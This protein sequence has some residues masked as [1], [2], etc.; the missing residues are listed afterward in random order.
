MPNV[1]VD[2]IAK[3]FR[4]E[5]VTRIKCAN[6]PPKLVGFLANEDPSAKKYAEWAAKTMKEDG[7][8]FDLRVV[9]KMDLDDLLFKANND[10]SVH[11]ILIF[12]P[13]FG[14]EASFTGCSRD[15]FLR[16]TIS[17]EKDVEG[18]CHLYRSNLYRNIRY[19][20]KERSL[21][22]ILPCTPLAVI[23][24]LEAQGVYDSSLPVGSRLQGKVITVVN[25]SEVVGRP[26]AALLANDGATVYSIDIDS[27]YKVQ[28]GAKCELVE[29]STEDACRT[30]QVVVL[31]VPSKAFKLKTSCIQPNTLVVNVASFKNVDPTELEKIDGVQYVAAVGK[32]TVSVLERNLLRLYDNFHRSVVAEYP[33]SCFSAHS[34]QQAP[35]DLLFWSAA[36]CVACTVVSSA[37]SVYLSY[38]ASKR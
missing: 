16:D 31:G 3:P 1:P 15:D 37:L 17:P 6:P 27:T 11:G 18:L 34:P 14:A 25:R 36:T 2:A 9:D 5:I 8:I 35:S 29:V 33:A 28:R 19:M 20:D 10:P 38:V 32:V 12:Y 24:I 21:K 13:V 4:E 26:L 23:K 7:I 30:S 22:C